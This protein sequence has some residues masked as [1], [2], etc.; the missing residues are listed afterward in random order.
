MPSQPAA[1]FHSLPFSCLLTQPGHHTPEV[2]L[3]ASHA[4]YHWERDH[5][6]SLQAD[7][8]ACPPPQS[9]RGRRPQPGQVTEPSSSSSSRASSAHG[10]C[11]GSM[12]RQCEEASPSHLPAC[13]MN[14]Q[15][16]SV[17]TNQLTTSLPGPSP[18]HHHRWRRSLSA[19]MPPAAQRGG[20]EGAA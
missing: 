14:F 4:G 18:G 10:H 15:Q 11:Q 6:P 20:M 12:S 19:L 16:P 7:M 9:Q 3:P 2:S 17:S 8:P 5:F 1:T 13:F